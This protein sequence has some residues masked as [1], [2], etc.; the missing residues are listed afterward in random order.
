MVVRQPSRTRVLLACSGVRHTVRGFET[1]TLEAA[2]ALPRHPALDVRLADVPA[3]PRE[4]RAARALGAAARRDGYFAEQ[5]SYALALLPTLARFRPDVV[6]LS[7]WAL[8]GALGRLR[9]VTRSR[10]R[11]LLSNGAAGPPPYDWTI[12]HVQQLTP[13][14]HDVAIQAGEPPHR[15]TM[16]PLG[17]EVPSAPDALGLDD[18]GAL[19]ER[20]GLPR[21]GELL[22]CVAALNNWSK[23]L[24]YVI[25]E[26][27]SLAARPYLVLLG[28]REP[29]TPAVLAEAEAR[30][31]AGFTARTV[32]PDQ[33]PDHYRAADALVLGS[34]HEAMARVLVEALGHGLPTLC[35]DGEVMRFVTGDHALRADLADPGALAGLVEQRRR[36]GDSHEA[37]QARNRFARER[38]GWEALL[39]RYA[40][41]IER[42][43]RG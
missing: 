15:H 25:R 42:A 11:L 23:R 26:V 3:V 34:L 7:D 36:R 16:L 17:V 21:E 8:A 35:H 29:E 4:S 13:H 41:M 19:R 22:L 20:L 9:A 24:D 2:T 18:R 10:F 43:A 1:F 12:D 33:V 38:F 39:P 28:A 14:L 30:L 32:P 31:G 40:D 37:R 6:Y 27:A 5:M